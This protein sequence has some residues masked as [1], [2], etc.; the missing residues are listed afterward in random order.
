MSTLRDTRR[1]KFPLSLL[2]VGVQD[3]GGVFRKI[4]LGISIGDTDINGA[5]CS[6][7][8]KTTDKQVSSE[9]TLVLV[10]VAGSCWMILAC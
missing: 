3:L 10:Q 2:F 4:A 9:F 1:K 7:G 6:A 5:I 8:P